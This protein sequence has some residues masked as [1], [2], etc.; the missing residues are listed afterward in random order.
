MFPYFDLIRD[1]RSETKPAPMQLFSPAAPR[2]W[3]NFVPGSAAPNAPIL[4][5]GV[6]DEYSHGT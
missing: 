6:P 4:R 2:P 5:S 1:P 3:S